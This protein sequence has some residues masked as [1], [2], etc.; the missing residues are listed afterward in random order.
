[1]WGLALHN[2]RSI[3]FPPRASKEVNTMKAHVLFD[4]AGNVGA[5]F[6]PSEARTSLGP[7]IAGIFSSRSLSFPPG[8]WSFPIRVSSAGTDN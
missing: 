2:L 5:I 4:E 8:G 6:R 3:G 7:F 1:M